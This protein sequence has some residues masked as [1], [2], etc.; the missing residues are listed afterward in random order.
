MAMEAGAPR[1]VPTIADNV[2][3]TP[4]DNREPNLYAPTVKES[5][6]S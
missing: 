6:I 5:V 2:V 1:A 3:G 4:F